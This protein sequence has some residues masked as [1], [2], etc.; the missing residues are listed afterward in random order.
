MA[1]STRKFMAKGF[2][3]YL[4]S[5]FVWYHLKYLSGSWEVLRRPILY[6]SKPEVFPGDEG[7]PL[8]ENNEPWEWFDHGFSKRTAHL[9]LNDPNRFKI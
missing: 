7:Y 6:F 9:N 8:K 5:L 2:F 3:I 1:M 4:G